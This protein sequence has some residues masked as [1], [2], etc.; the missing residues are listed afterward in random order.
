MADGEEISILVE[1][2]GDFI[3]NQTFELNADSAMF[4]A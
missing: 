1:M 4:D 3:F 2:L